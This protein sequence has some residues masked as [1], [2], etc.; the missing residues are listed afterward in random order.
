LGT[1]LRLG[2]PDNYPLEAIEIL[3]KTTKCTALARPKSWKR[4]GLRGVADDTMDIDDANDVDKGPK[5][6]GVELKMRTEYMVD[7]SADK[8]DNEEHEEDDKRH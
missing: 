5:K 4:F 8:E 7:H 3:V 2:D 1:V 6:Y